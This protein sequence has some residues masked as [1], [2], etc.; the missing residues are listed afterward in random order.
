MA[1]KLR[2]SMI[3]SSASPTKPPSNRS[4]TII[5]GARYAIWYQSVSTISH[6]IY[7]DLRLKRKRYQPQV[8]HWPTWMPFSFYQRHAAYTKS[9]VE[10]LYAWPLNWAEQRI[11]LPFFSTVS[12]CSD[13]CCFAGGWNCPSISGSGTSSG[14]PKR[15]EGGRGNTD[16]RRRKT[17]L[18][19]CIRRYV[20]PH[21]ARQ[22]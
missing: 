21:S 7:L 11:V 2:P 16:P 1:I 17:Y 10:K 3:H 4:V 9:L 14:R 15:Q 19:R 6:S 12:S 8:K 22:H 5:W 13:P 18:Q 20:V